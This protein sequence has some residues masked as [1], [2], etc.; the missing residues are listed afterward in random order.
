MRRWSRGCLRVLPRQNLL[1]IFCWLCII[2]IF[3]PG[4]RNIVYSLI[5]SIIMVK[6]NFI[7]LFADSFRKNWDLPGYS[8]YGEN[9]T[10][11]YA[12]I[13]RQVARLHLLFE[14]CHIRRDDKIALI[15]RNSSNWAITYVATVTYGAVIALSCTTSTRTTHHIANHSESKLPF[16]G[17]SIWESLE[18]EKLTQVKAVFSFARFPL[19]HAAQPAR[20]RRGRMGRRPIPSTVWNKTNCNL[21]TSPACLPNAIRAAFTRDDIRYADKPNSELASINYTR[22]PRAS[23]RV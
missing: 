15:G 22:A 2:F 11:T 14:Q 7:E 5:Y 13:A 4:K 1:H 20:G 10:L 19:P 21:T 16:T 23:A 8:D 12:D 18:E 9:N 3:A 17:D 6:E